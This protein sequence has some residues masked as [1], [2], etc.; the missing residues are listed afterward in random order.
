MPIA[1][2]R[3]AG[4][5]IDHACDCAVPRC[6]LSC[7]CQTAPTTGPGRGGSR[8]AGPA[9]RT[10]NALL[11]DGRR[12]G[13]AEG[14]DGAR[15]LGDPAGRVWPG[16]TLAW[17]EVEGSPQR[18][19]V[20]I[21]P[22]AL[23]WVCC[24][25]GHAR[26]RTSEV[27]V[28]L[29]RGGGGWRRRRRWRREAREGGCGRDGALLAARMGC[30]GLVRCL[31]FACCSQPSVR[32]SPPPPQRRWSGRRARST[33]APAPSNRGN[34]NNNM[35][36]NTSTQEREREALNRAMPCPKQ[37]HT[38]RRHVGHVVDDGRSRCHRLS[39]ASYPPGAPV[40][41]AAI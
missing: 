33:P 27:R 21:C 8:G 17:W 15:A 35:N 36:V 2:L 26:R 31:S 16:A 12:G 40:W 5:D 18:R 41:D 23:C 39:W 28:T 19:V 25:R 9:R 11:C 7:S 13:R 1:A 4:R 6:P 37:H 29:E 30:R 34:N 38:G 22:P 3:H 14:G 32:T 24:T 10:W 20:V